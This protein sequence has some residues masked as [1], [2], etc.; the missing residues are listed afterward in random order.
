MFQ[1]EIHF[2]GAMNMGSA[3]REWRS[4]PRNRHWSRE[5]PEKSMVSGSVARRVR[6][7]PHVGLTAHMRRM[8]RINSKS[9]PGRP[10]RRRDFHRQNILNPARCQPITVSGRKI[11]NGTF[12]FGQALLSMIQSHLSHGRSFGLCAR[13]LST[14]I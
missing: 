13:R 10:R 2:L 3:M 12:Q 6:G 5:A 4:R 7:L 9:F 11:I 8:S 14:V 1:A